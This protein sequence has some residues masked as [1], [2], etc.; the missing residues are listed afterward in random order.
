MSEAGADNRPQ[1]V[2]VGVPVGEQQPPAVAAERIR[3]LA[4]SMLPYQEAMVQAVASLCAIP[5]VKGEATAEAPYGVAT[6]AALLAFLELGTS[7]GFRAVELDG[8]AGYL[9]WGSGDRLVAALGHLDVVPAGDGWKQDP[10][11]PVIL[12]D[13]IVARGTEDDKGPIVAA[14]FAVKALMDEGF[15]PRGR[16]RLI[17]G[18]DEESGSTCMEHYVRVAELPAAGFT[19]DAGFPVIYAEKGI[20]CFE[21][22]V[23]GGQPDSDGLRLVRA[24]GGARHNM[25]P[26][27]CSLTFSSLRLESGSRADELYVVHGKAAH[28]S[29]PWTGD[30]AIAN[31][32]R[33]AGARLTAVGLT[34]PFVEFFRQ[35][36]VSGW[37]G[38]G[39]DI[40]DQDVSGPLTINAGILSLDESGATLTVD[41]RHPV[42]LSL[43]DLSARL[44]AR[45]GELG[46]GCRLVYVLAPLYLRRDSSLVQTLMAVYREQTATAAEAVAIGGGTYA[47]A[48]PNIVAFGPTFPEEPDVCHQVNEF[49]T[50]TSLMASA[51]IYREAFRALAT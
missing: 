33:E 32:M 13:R 38:Q 17:V 35:A 28:A 5:S 14:L 23:P 8:R 9:E 6:R 19:P 4:A 31:A 48:I 21:L 34:H 30:N 37:D 10:F 45:A 43:A 15:E 36:F 27:A 18:L 16:I 42:T 24:T 20:A 39:L 11:K 50:F 25:V 7:L 12:A 26:A 29:R 1:P 3:M 47:R 49:I 44:T 22:T 46:A 40:A 41:I 2:I 51:A